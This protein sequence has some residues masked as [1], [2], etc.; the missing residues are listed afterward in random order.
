MKIIFGV[1]KLQ[2]YSRPVVA[3]GVFDGVHLAH[4]RILKSVVRKARSI[5]GTS[6]VVTFWPHPQKQDTIFSLQYRLHE[7]ARQG[8]DICIVI[9]FDKRFSELSADRF[10]RDILVKKIGVNFLY[11]GK[12]FKFG[13]DAQGD[14][15]LLYKLG[16]QYGFKIEVFDI[17]K[18]NGHSI[19]STYIRKLIYGG[20]LDLAAKFL[21]RPVGIFGTVVKGAS[22]ATRLGFPTANIDPHHEVLP[23]SGIYAVK[24]IFDNHRL[25]GICYIGKKKTFIES[26]LRYIEV[27]ILGFNKNIY[28]KDIEVQFI[29][30][31]RGDKKFSS[32]QALIIQIRK[33]VNLA[34][35]I[36]SSA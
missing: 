29:K 14:Y 17:I 19:S 27:H 23:P 12:N 15:R 8:I 30:K 2:K 7:I 24:V 21:L 6:V 22:L 3:L 11:V 13:R 31:I 36:L 1:S 28:E 35:R 10:A 16:G 4:R 20:K 26:R 32:Q 9:D 18:I 34:Q 5:K 33:D 25:R